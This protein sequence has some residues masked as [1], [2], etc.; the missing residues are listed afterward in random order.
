[1]APGLRRPEDW[2]QNLRIQRAQAYITVRSTSKCTDN[3]FLLIDRFPPFVEH[4]SHSRY[5]IWREYN[6]SRVDGTPLG[7]EPEHKL[8]HNTEVAAT[9]TNGPK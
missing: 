2:K 8:C 7:M 4:S 5:L 6:V 1:M 9:T 3:C